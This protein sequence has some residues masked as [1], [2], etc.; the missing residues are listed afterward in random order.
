VT[1]FFVLTLCVFKQWG[2]RSSRVNYLQ[3]PFCPNQYQYMDISEESDTNMAK[4][5]RGLLRRF[6][7]LSGVEP[8]L[9]A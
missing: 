5:V 6:H 7:L 1:T 3:S 4:L 9:K 8:N 2:Y